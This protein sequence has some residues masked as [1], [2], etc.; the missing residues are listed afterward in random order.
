MQNVTLFHASNINTTDIFQ[1]LVIFAQIL[2]IYPKNI[3]TTYDSRG[4]TRFYVV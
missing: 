3:K 2:P 1:F 4:F